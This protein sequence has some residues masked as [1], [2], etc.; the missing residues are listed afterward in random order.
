M[1]S[2]VFISYSH[3]DQPTAQFISQNL[4]NQGFDVWTDGQIRPGE[5]WEEAITSA[6]KKSDIF[7]PLVSFDLMNSE[8]SIAE[9]GAAYGMDKNIF[10]VLV[11]GDIR[12]MPFKFRDFQVLDATKMNKYELVSKIIEGISRMEEQAEKKSLEHAYAE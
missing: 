11:S 6:M 3:K 4:T 1:K 5:S 2:T 8:H 10:P 12:F 9:L 7:M